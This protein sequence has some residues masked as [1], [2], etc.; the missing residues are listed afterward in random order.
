MDSYMEYMVKR[1]KT[2]GDFIIKGVCVWA[3]IVLCMLSWMFGGVPLIK[4]LLL[5]LTIGMLFLSWYVIFPRTD[6]EYEYLYCDKTI[7]VDVIYSK[8]KRKNLATY[9][10]DRIEILAPV[11]SHRLDEYKNKNLTVKD[12]ASGMESDAHKPY[13][14]IYGGNE[15]VILDLPSEFVKMVQNNGP[16][17]VF[18]D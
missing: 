11:N 13:A 9:D 12:Y 5:A 17:K 7:T 6:V 18:F 3:I 10:L 2:K 4:Y 14:L 1:G 16:R 8:S 15:K